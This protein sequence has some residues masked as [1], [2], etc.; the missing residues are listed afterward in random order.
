MM[1]MTTPTP[2]TGPQPAWRYSNDELAAAGGERA[3]FVGPEHEP[4]AMTALTTAQQD[5][6]LAI[7][8]R[9]GFG[10]WLNNPFSGWHREHVPVNVLWYDTDDRLHLARIGT[11]G[12]I[13]REVTV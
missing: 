3:I 7:Q 5:K 12:L 10:F 9:E 11:T 1:T 6:T 4:Q 8:A 2:T 13:L